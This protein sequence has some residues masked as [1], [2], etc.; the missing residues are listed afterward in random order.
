MPDQSAERSLIC[1]MLL[2]NTI[3]PSIT[4]SGHQFTDSYCVTA[5][6]EIQRQYTLHGGANKDCLLS[7]GMDYNWVIE[8]SEYVPTSANFQF[9]EKKIRDAYKMAFERRLVATANDMAAGILDGDVIKYLEEQIT[10]FSADLTEYK[11]ISMSQVMRSGLDDI[12]RRYKLKGELPGISTGLSELNSMI[13]GFQKRHY[14]IIGA[15]PSDGKTAIGINFLLDAA[16]D[17]KVAGMIS[18]ESAVQELGL[19]ISAR[20][21]RIDAS[22][23]ALGLLKQADFGSLM[24][25]AGR[26]SNYKILFYDEPNP[27]IETIERKA[28]EWKRR[29]GLEILFIDYVQIIQG[30]V[31][32]SF[33][34][35]IADVSLRLKAIARNLD[36]PVVCM[37]QLGRANADKMPTASDI[38]GSDQITRDADGIILL[39]HERDKET[40]HITESRIIVDK[41]RDGKKGVMKVIF[42]G[43]YLNF[44]NI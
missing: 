2:D 30:G 15:R 25:A 16:K 26:I 32:D 17:G 6:G 3:I 39:H 44:K 36:I 9:Y 27:R 11:T 43:E 18:A 8:T 24:D 5:F 13:L 12:E 14:Y 40:N 22:F 41:A 29:N 37:A 38:A 31:G 4:V 35:R 7:I 21:A 23:L 34:E 1:Q 28:R 42:E 19:R 10:D 33:H 20:E